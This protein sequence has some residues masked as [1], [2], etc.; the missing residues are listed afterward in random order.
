MLSLKKMSLEYEQKFEKSCGYF[1]ISIILHINEFM[2]ELI[3]TIS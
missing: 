2:A 1:K 3:I